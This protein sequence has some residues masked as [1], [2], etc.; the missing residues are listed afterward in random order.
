MTLFKKRKSLG[1][2]RLQIRISA[3]SRP[4]HPKCAFVEADA[5][6]HGW[7][8]SDYLAVGDSR[9]D[10]PLFERAGFQHRADAAP[11]ARRTATVARAVDP[12][13]VGAC[14]ALKRLRAA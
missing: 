14:L 7:S 1:Q 6:W 2:A 11:E 3:R 13:L 10:V 4:G 5:A 9:S 8:L 12:D